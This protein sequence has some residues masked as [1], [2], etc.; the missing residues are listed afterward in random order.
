MIRESLSHKKS[1]LDKTFNWRG[2]EVSRLE[3]FSDAVFAFA[4]TLIVVSLEVPKTFDQLMEIMSGF[5]AFLICFVFLIMLWYE[6]FLYFRRYGL[7][8]M[9]IIIINM[10]F[11][12]LILYYVYPLK[13]LMT[14]IVKGLTGQT[15]FTILPN[16][17]KLYPV[18]QTQM[19]TV[20]VVYGL[21][22]MAVYALLGLMYWYAY[23]KRGELELSEIEILTT[24]SEVIGQLA[25][26][27]VGLLS[28]CVVLLTGSGGVAGVTYFL[29]GPLRGLLGWQYGRKLSRL[30]LTT[31]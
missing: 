14:L 21:G 16:G 22:Y 11:L 23:R 5:G 25:M 7:N 12:F 31:Q 3:G 1:G 13:F 6:H 18:T 2:T 9:F 27:G 19:P 30:K 10:L 15:L 17:E 24:R 4:M 28:V 29:I 20:M 8:T 26:V